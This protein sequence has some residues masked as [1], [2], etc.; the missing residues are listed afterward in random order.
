[1]GA[2]QTAAFFG[3]ENDPYSERALAHLEQLFDVVQSFMGTNHV[4]PR[5]VPPGVLDVDWLFCFKSKT[6]L[7]ADTLSSVRKGSINFHTASPHYPG[8]GGVNWAL[9]NGDMEAAITVHHITTEVDAGP[10]IAVM[11][12]PC[13][14]ATTVEALLELTY[15]QHLQAFFD[16]T[17]QIAEKGLGW[18]TETQKRF[19]DHNWGQHTYR[20]RDLEALKEIRLDMNADEVERRIRATK[21]RQYG[22][23]VHVG[24]HKFSLSDEFE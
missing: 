15:R 10:I 3:L 6:I 21:F 24:G 17:A 16:V 5:D 12:F 23:F 8:S 2:G 9:Y 11:P 7:R 20:I 1:M 18:V 14:D 22:P 4:P 19:C 13:V